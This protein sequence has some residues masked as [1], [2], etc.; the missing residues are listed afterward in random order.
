MWKMSIFH[1]KPQKSP[2]TNAAD[3]AKFPESRSRNRNRN[4]KTAEPF[5]NAC[6]LYRE[7]QVGNSKNPEARMP[8]R[9]IVAENGANALSSNSAPEEPSASP[10]VGKPK[11]SPSENHLD[12]TIKHNGA[13][14]EHTKLALENERGG[15]KSQKTAG[16][17]RIAK[18]RP[19]R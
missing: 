14:G 9:K 13:R 7:S 4:R 6:Q 15:A 17:R 5:C 2:A 16:H 10:D 11:K 18:L 12:F 1:R 19:D 8:R 3:C